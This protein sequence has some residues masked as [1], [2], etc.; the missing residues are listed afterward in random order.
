[1][2]RKT[3]GYTYMKVVLLKDVRDMGRAGSVLDVS[4][5]HGLNMLIP[6][7]LAVLATPA[8]IKRAEGVKQQSDEKRSVEAKLIEE[9]LSALA[10]TRVS[11]LKKAN[12]QGHLYD[13]VDAKEIA[14][15][16][17]LPLEAIK[18]EKPIKELGSFDIPVAYGE[19]FG[20]ITIS[21]EA[22]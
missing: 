12:E 8:A 7:G 9:R 21:I 15:E 20:S 17:K 2:G 22:E 1:M 3:L 5:G 11:I 6:R 14:E 4:D 19:N 16:A 10:E 18:L 13:A